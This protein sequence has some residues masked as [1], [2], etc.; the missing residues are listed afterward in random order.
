MAPVQVNTRMLGGVGP[1]VPIKQELDEDKLLEWFQVMLNK[2]FSE[3]N[4]KN[5]RLLDDVRN[6]KDKME[7]ML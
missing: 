6:T 4:H 3:Y 7:I 5:K 1:S 2:K